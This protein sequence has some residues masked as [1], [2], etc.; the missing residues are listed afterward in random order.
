MPSAYTS[1]LASDISFALLALTQL[2]KFNFHKILLKK[3]EM[4]WP[5]KGEDS[6]VAQ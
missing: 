1:N 4:W 5:L 3:F 6:M 2:S